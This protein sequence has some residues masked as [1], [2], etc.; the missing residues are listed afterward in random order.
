MSNFY[1]GLKDELDAEYTRQLKSLQSFLDQKTLELNEDFHK[2][3]KALQAACSHENETKE[4]EFD[5]HHREYSE[6]FHC[7]DCGK[8][9]RTV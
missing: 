1:R 6:V 8:Y 3:Y 5:Y 9:L 2:R 4:V 7:A